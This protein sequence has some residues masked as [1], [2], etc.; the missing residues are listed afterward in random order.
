METAYLPNEIK[1]PVKFSDGKLTEIVAHGVQ[2]SEFESVALTAKPIQKAHSKDLRKVV[3][4]YIE[5]GTF[6]DDEYDGIDSLICP[7]LYALIPCLVPDENLDPKSGY[8]RSF[9]ARLKGESQRRYAQTVHRDID[10]VAKENLKTHNIL[11]VWWKIPQVIRFGMCGLVG[12]LLH[13]YFNF[14]VYWTLSSYHSDYKSAVAFGVSNFISLLWKHMLH[15]NLVFNDKTHYWQSLLT[16]YASY[17]VSIAASPLVNAFYSVW[18][19]LDMR[20][21]YWATIASFGVFNFMI[22]KF[23]IDSG[24]VKDVDLKQSLEMEQL[25]SDKEKV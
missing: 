22:L 17:S 21:A 10:E 18:V 2:N 13:Y 5:K 4:R 14:F 6:E 11:S 16:F 15:R 19:G 8:F 3:I 12:A 1:S 7:I 9:I 24:E 20:I 25:T 23:A